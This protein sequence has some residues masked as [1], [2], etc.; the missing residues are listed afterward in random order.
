MRTYRMLALAA[1]IC[2]G[3]WAGSAPIPPNEANP[4]P[5]MEV[6]SWVRESW[7]NTGASDRLRMGRRKSLLK[8]TF[9]AGEKEKTAFK[10]LTGFS[11]DAAGKLN[12]WVFA[13]DAETPQVSVALSTT[14][15]YVWHESKTFPLKQGWNALEVPLAKGNWK[16]EASKWQFDAG[17]EHLDDVRAV[18]LIVLNGKK[19]GWIVVEGVRADGDAAAKRVAE[20][21]EQMSGADF[22]KQA[23]AEQELIK[24]GRPA[25]EALYQLSRSD[26]T[27]VMLR[28]SFALRTIEEAQ[29]ELPEN[30]ELRDR[31]LAQREENKFQELSV[32]TSYILKSLQNERGKVLQLIKDGQAEVARGRVEF[33][34]LKFTKDEEKEAYRKSLDD[35]DVL[36]KELTTVVEASLKAEKEAEEKKKG[37]DGDGRQ[38]RRREEARAREEIRARNEDRD[39]DR[40]GD[41]GTER[42]SGATAH[43]VSPPIGTR[44]ANTKRQT[45]QQQARCWRKPRRAA[46]VHCFPGLLL[47]TKPDGGSPTSP[48]PVVRPWTGSALRSQSGGR[49]DLGESRSG[50]RDADTRA[51]RTGAAGTRRRRFRGAA[52]RM[53]AVDLAF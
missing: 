2:P 14:Q 30:P 23:E 34:T 9:D 25:M 52:T 44:A 47:E 32:R 24:V 3:L 37:G 26:R 22:E 12:L 13:P 42:V 40:G 1:L 5:G 28:A 33:P 15:A 36:T 50:R 39:E 41:A 18:N 8:L 7:G 20:L 10:H 45:L 29:E 38:A 49:A 4:A 35:L 16:T 53:R 17:V 43:V 46:N 19:A 51:D 11:A 21:I 48:I 6:G 31:L 27:A